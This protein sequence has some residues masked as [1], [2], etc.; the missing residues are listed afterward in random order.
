M[1]V[2]SY[3]VSTWLGITPMSFDQKTGQLFFKWN[4]SNTAFFF[5]NFL[6]CQGYLAFFGAVFY[7]HVRKAGI[8]GSFASSGYVVAVASINLIF[9]CIFVRRETIIENINKFRS[10]FFRIKQSVKNT[11]DDKC[12]LYFRS[13]LILVGIVPMV[14]HCTHNLFRPYAESYLSSFLLDPDLFPKGLSYPRL[15][16]AL[17]IFHH[18]YYIFL[19]FLS[20]VVT[21]LIPL[22]FALGFNESFDEL[23][24]NLMN[25]CPK[26]VE[27]LHPFDDSSDEGSICNNRPTAL[28][29]PNTPKL[30]RAGVSPDI[31]I[32]RPSYY[33]SS[34][35]PST[36]ELRSGAATANLACSTAITMHEVT[37]TSRRDSFTPSVHFSNAVGIRS[38]LRQHC[39][40]QRFLFSFNDSF[41]PFLVIFV[42]NIFTMCVGI[43]FFFIKSFAELLMDPAYMA[44]YLYHAVLYF[45]RGTLVLYNFGKV[46]ESASYTKHVL[47]AHLRVQETCRELRDEVQLFI[48]QLDDVYLAAGSYIYFSKGFLISFYGIMVT[49][50]AIM[51]EAV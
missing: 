11:I 38:I 9:W 21:D 50:V 18:G 10:D 45:G 3:K 26:P 43:S 28:S 5:F 17:S 2:V 41:T 33:G 7:R 25:L 49:Y 35:T 20:S 39:E 36:L 8:E 12:K 27:T 6:Q 1:D 32:S 30:R 44:L 34:P 40:V 19:S 48:S 37:A 13:Y 24:R 51:V 4:S 29:L 23:N 47:I 14:V 15:S 22:L 46:K 31:R 42:I 16:R